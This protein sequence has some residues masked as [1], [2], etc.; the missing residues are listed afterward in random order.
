MTGFLN[1]STS[2][3]LN[4]IELSQKG[5]LVNFSQYLDAVHISILNCDEMPGVRPRQPAYEIFSITRRFQ[6]SKSRSPRLMEP[7]AGGRQKRLP[8]LK[9]VI[10]P[11]LS[12]VA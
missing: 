12:G 10:L 4:D 5:F 6:Q 3:T 1:L 9:V 7:G 8:L 2:M 11:Q